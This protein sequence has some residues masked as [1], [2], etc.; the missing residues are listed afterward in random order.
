MGR[1][2]QGRCADRWK[3]RFGGGG[4]GGAWGI[5]ILILF[6][7]RLEGGGE[8]NGQGKKT[9]PTTYDMKGIKQHNRNLE[10]TSFTK[11]AGIK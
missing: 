7:F 3:P 4:P 1:E 2:G 8:G 5:L 9:K 10:T 6:E 11:P